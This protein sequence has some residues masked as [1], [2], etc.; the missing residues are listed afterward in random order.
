MPLVNF[1]SRSNLHITSIG[2]VYIAGLAGAGAIVIGLALWFV[3]R[4]FRKRAA[5]E[6]EDNMGPTFL[7]VHGVVRDDGMAEKHPGSLYAMPNRNI[8]WVHIDTPIVMP[9]KAIVRRDEPMGELPRKHNL[10]PGRLSPKPFSFATGM[11][12][13]TSEQ[14][15][16]NQTRHSGNSLLS[17]GNGQNRFSV[18]SISSNT[19]QGPT[20][21]SKR[22]VRQLFNPVLPD[23]LLVATPGEQLT[24][25]QS[26]EDGWCLVGREHSTSSKPLFQQ[27][28]ASQ[29]NIEFGVIPAWCFIKPVKGLRV[30]RPVRNC[31]LG[32]A[33][34]YQGPGFS[35]RDE[36]ISW[37]NF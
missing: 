15:V 8:S 28:L 22:K 27:N 6:G 18:S 5:R 32:I 26:F 4:M 7:S 14:G 20:T 25:I 29:N 33:V 36:I 12:A 16:G 21:G 31:S 11:V 24:L 1:D 30:E 19:S 13:N 37:S 10:R 34:Q 17:A 3:W 9:E 35:S 2:P 23:E